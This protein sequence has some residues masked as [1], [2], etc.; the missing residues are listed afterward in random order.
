MIIT[1]E[2][3][4]H[5]RRSVSTLVKARVRLWARHNIRNSEFGLC[6][7]AAAICDGVA[8]ARLPR[9]IK[10]S[11]LPRR[12]RAFSHAVDCHQFGSG[13]LASKTVTCLSLIKKTNSHK[14]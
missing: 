7:V 10:P 6:V 14:R 1:E 3:D 11:P 13:W 2:H 4:V 8:D 5:P 9:M 12:S